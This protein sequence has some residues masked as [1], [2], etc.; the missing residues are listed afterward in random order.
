MTR[1]LL[2]ALCVLVALGGAFAL[3]AAL[4]YSQ[5]RQATERA[6]AHAGPAADS[7]RAVAEGYADAAAE[8][9]RLTLIL[10]DSLQTQRDSTARYRAASRRAEAYAARL[11]AEADDARTAYAL[12]LGAPDSTRLAAC[13]AALTSCTDARRAQAAALDSS[14][15]LNASL[16]AENGLLTRQAE[17]QGVQI[18]HLGLAYDAR[19]AEAGRLR[20]QLVGV[21]AAAARYRRRLAVERPLFAVAGFAAGVGSGY[22]LH[23]VTD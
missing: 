9:Q 10:A 21:E 20:L 18:A 8:W 7:L 15:A 14:E 1:A 11:A 12:T 19:A 23:A 5:C 6:T 3:G 2:I 13:D 17:L 22:L 4:G 16:A